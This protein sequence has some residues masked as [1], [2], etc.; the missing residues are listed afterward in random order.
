MYNIKVSKRF[1]DSL[2]HL[3]KQRTWLE[4]KIL[5]LRD[6][7]QQYGFIPHVFDIYDIKQIKQW[8]RRVKFIPFRVIIRIWEDETIYLEEIFKRKG[9]SDYKKFQ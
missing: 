3:I 6:D 8:R 2:Q 4:K 1:L 5:Q 9:N 7:L